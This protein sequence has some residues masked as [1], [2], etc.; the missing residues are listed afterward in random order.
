MLRG[1]SLPSE[2]STAQPSGWASYQLFPYLARDP[3]LMTSILARFVFSWLA[4]IHSHFFHDCQISD[5]FSLCTLLPLH[6]SS[7]SVRS[8][9]T[10]TNQGS[11][12]K[13]KSPSTTELCINL[14]REFMQDNIT[15]NKTT[16]EITEVFKELSIHDEG[17][18]KSSPPLPASSYSSARRGWQ[19]RFSPWI[20]R[21][22]SSTA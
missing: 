19:V 3:H 13:T 11:G 4:Y 15:R 22:Y 1:L 12:S 2:N 14:V 9:S 10:T 6:H 7:M 5:S 17:N 16:W 20:A 18:P 21:N 8:A